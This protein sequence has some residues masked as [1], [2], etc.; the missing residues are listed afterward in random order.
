[1]IFKQRSVRKKGGIGCYVNSKLEHSIRNDL[2][3]FK[4]GIFES[5]AIE[6]KCSKKSKSI[7][8][9]VY[10]PP[11]VA[12]NNISASEQLEIFQNSI[13]EILEKLTG[14]TAKSI[15]LGTSTYVY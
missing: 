2:S 13:L 15:L 3:I 9:N 10:R 1:M 6:V 5:Q 8:I 7:F 4:E 11:S 12:F 14:K